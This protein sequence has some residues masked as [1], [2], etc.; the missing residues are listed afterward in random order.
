MSQSKSP[1]TRFPPAIVVHS[2]E[3]ARLA[4]A[5]ARPVTLLS[6][7]AAAVYA[8]PAWWRSLVDL[9][10]T[11]E[12]D[13]VDCADAPGR[14]LEALALGCRN[15]ILLRCPA[16]PSVAER[17]AASGALLLSERPASLDLADPAVARRIAA[18]LEVG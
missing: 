2:G 18:W 12:P 8:G 5:A 11:T 16:W 10:G 7:P 14:A 4:L 9:T 13:I 17:A 1:L 3:H 6:A 15:V